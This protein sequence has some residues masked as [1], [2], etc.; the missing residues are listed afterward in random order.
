MT[1]G[2]R[3]PDPGFLARARHARGNDNKKRQAS[4]EKRWRG[5]GARASTAGTAARAT[6]GAR[7]STVKRLRR[8]TS[9]QVA[10]NYDSDGNFTSTI[11]DGVETDF[12]YD[13]DERVSS[14]TPSSAAPGVCQ[15]NWIKVGQETFFGNA[16]I[17]YSL[18][19][20]CGGSVMWSGTP[21]GGTCQMR[22][23]QI[24]SELGPCFC[25][26]PGPKTGCLQPAQ[27]EFRNGQ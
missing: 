27:P 19:V 24:G 21:G 2:A 11:V 13:G 16:C 25:S 12:T 9:T 1:V 26:P 3:V 22:G 15:G 10:L 6:I 14:Q 8:N 18:C 23:L 20:P 17:C 7:A 4:D 5:R